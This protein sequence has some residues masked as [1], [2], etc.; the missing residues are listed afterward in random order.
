MILNNK[1]M[2][3]SLMVLA[4]VEEKGMLGYA[5]M[6]NRQ[7]IAD[8]VQAYSAQR[9][10]LLHKYGTDIGKG[11]Y[12]LTNENATLF[13]EELKPFSELT[14]DVPVMRVSPEVF[15]GGN[16]T[17]NQMFILDWMVEE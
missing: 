10:E 6:R 15:Y 14:V 1:Q 12:T 16:L 11:Q 7:K 2:F 17:S 8:E 9:D 3:D 13:Y 5:V 4:Q